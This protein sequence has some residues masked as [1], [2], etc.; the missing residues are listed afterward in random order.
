MKEPFIRTVFEHPT[1]ERLPVSTEFEDYM[2]IYSPNSE[3]DETFVA[4]MV[5]K[6]DLLPID[7]GFVQKQ[8]L[9]GNIKKW[10]NVKSVEK[11][12]AAKNFIYYDEKGNPRSDLKLGSNGKRFFGFIRHNNEGSMD[13]TN[14]AM[15]K[16]GT[17]NEKA[18][19]KLT[20]ELTK[21]TMYSEGWMNKRNRLAD[22]VTN[23]LNFYSGNNPTVLTRQ[24]ENIVDETGDLNYVLESIDKRT[25]LSGMAS[26]HITDEEREDYLAHVNRK[27]MSLMDYVNIRI[28]QAAKKLNLR[29]VLIDYVPD[30]DFYAYDQHGNKRRNLKQAD[31]VEDPAVDRFLDIIPEATTI[32]G[33]IMRKRKR[34]G[35]SENEIM[36]DFLGNNYEIS[37][38]KQMIAKMRKEL[39]PKEFN[40]FFRDINLDITYS[41]KSYTDEELKLMLQPMG[42]PDFVTFYAPR[43]VNQ[44]R[45]AL[46]EL[47]PNQSIDRTLEEYRD[48]YNRIVAQQGKYTYQ[49]QEEFERRQERENKQWERESE[50]AWKHEGRKQM[51]EARERRDRLKSQMADE[52]LLEK[53]RMQEFRSEQQAAKMYKKGYVVGP[54]GRWVKR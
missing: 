44:L 39:S 52:K 26:R 38:V 22:Y 6:N 43:I 9:D 21:E 50:R 53:Y 10:R 32:I 4:N 17:T 18:L 23:F 5:F 41:G 48:K 40:D 3:S 27:N 31:I 20:N 34:Y 54:D 49:Q 15:V 11:N 28:K 16:I 13:F 19:D 35:Y 24:E 1:E 25:N 36:T 37:Y 42:N 30:D 33:G 8:D 51:Q 46:E 45:D 7:T 14:T 29:H 12:V 47:R 2:N